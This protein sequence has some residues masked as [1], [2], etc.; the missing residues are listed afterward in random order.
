MLQ[1]RRTLLYTLPIIVLIG[2]GGAI[3]G[4]EWQR[5]RVIADLTRQLASDDAGKA[6]A[7]VRQIAAI[8]RPPLSVLVEAAAAERLAVA[9]AAQTEI[10]DLLRG[11][12]NDVEK[13]ATTSHV[14]A[15]V[16][17]LASQL[18]Q[19]RYAFGSRD[20]S[21]LASVT[22][23]I[24]RVANG[25]HEVAA[26]LIAMHCDEVA[27]AI[28]TTLRSGTRG[29][30][31]PAPANATAINSKAQ[32]DD[33]AAESNRAP[34]EREFAAI[35]AR[36]LLA[37]LPESKQQSAADDHA[38]TAPDRG[39]ADILAEHNPLRAMPSAAP[40]ADAATPPKL[41][42]DSDPAD[43]APTAPESN[44]GQDWSMPMMRMTPAKSAAAETPDEASSKDLE[45][46]LAGSATLAADGVS[47]RELL[48]WWK[49]GNESQRH[50]V[51][52]LL[53]NRGLKKLPPK[54]VEQCLSDDVQERLRLVDNVMKVPGLDGRPWLML[55]GEDDS[56]EVR[57][58][59]VTL[60]MTS[61][62]GSLINKA[63][64]VSIHDH[65][66]RIADLATRLRDR[67]MSSVRR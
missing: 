67:R 47:T 44:V 34:L 8:S 6:T 60:M 11:W 39:D 24:V 51:E 45:R 22:H 40:A 42:N 17:E 58:A 2:V 23:A 21:W 18:A 59:A 3:G 37:S 33:A 43:E 55:L 26:P 38:T 12:E 32:T 31:T 29:V 10:A 14:A 62:D 36:P 61:E 48:Q 20:Y 41:F 19:H 28:G 63:W 64:Q 7:A 30:S 16:A 56:A 5:S 27:A 1:K 25:C 54:L 52:R 53:A 66:P 50:E 65:D 9:Q 49:T 15:R 35:P 46:K 57:F 4:L 13:N